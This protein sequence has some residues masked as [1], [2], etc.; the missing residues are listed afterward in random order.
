MVGLVMCA[1]MIKGGP[2][3]KNPKGMGPKDPELVVCVNVI[4]GGQGPRTRFAFECFLWGQDPR[5][6]GTHECLA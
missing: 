1:K 3:P 4:K 2:G 5:T 6:R